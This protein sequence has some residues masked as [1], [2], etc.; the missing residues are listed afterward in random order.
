MTGDGQYDHSFFLLPAKQRYQQQWYLD[1]EL[2]RSVKL[3]HT[4]LL[5]YQYHI[6]QH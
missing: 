4:N 2:F 6:I 1:M 3:Y 5:R